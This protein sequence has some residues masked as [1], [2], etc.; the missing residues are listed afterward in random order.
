MAHMV[1]VGFFYGKKGFRVKIP[2]EA[3]NIRIKE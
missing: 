3:N 1:T 2:K